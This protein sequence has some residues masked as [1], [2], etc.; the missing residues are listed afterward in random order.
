M[1]QRESL[2]VCGRVTLLAECDCQAISLMSTRTPDDPETQLAERLRRG[3]AAAVGELYDLYYDRLYAFV[4]N[5]VDRNRAVAEEIVQE[6][7]LT[8]VRSPGNYKGRSRMYTW[9]CGIA[10]NKVK[11]T[12]RRKGRD[13]QRR[14]DPPTGED[15]TP[16]LVLIDSE[17]LPQELVES[18]ATKEMVRNALSSL[19]D[20]YRQV[21]IMKYAEQM[22]ASEIGILMGRSE[23]AVESMLSRARLAL[24]DK[25]AQ[26]DR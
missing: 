7:W 3:D 12:W 11:D 6:V 25:I 23:K 26:T 14:Y 20:N 15:F 2:S 9:L 13:A 19:P 4:F 16:E 21:L 18:E 17:P 10:L 22:S 1:M 5:Q 24:R 8:A